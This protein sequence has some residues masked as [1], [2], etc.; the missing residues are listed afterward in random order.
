MAIT[1][2]MVTPQINGI[3]TNVDPAE[4][5]KLWNRSPKGL[6]GTIGF[7]AQPPHSIFS[8]NICVVFL[9]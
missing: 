1:M 7:V 3:G 2:L 6:A 4:D 9:G 8:E 5:L